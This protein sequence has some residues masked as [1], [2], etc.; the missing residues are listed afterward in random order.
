MDGIDRQFLLLCYCVPFCTRLGES[1]SYR[2]S[3]NLFTKCTTII[4]P[5]TRAAG[6]R[7]LECSSFCCSNVL[8]CVLQESVMETKST[9]LHYSRWLKLWSK[10][11]LLFLFYPSTKSNTILYV[12][13]FHLVQKPPWIS[14]KKNYHLKNINFQSIFEVNECMI[15][16][17]IEDFWR[18]NFNF[19]LQ[20]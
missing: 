7:D 3:C 15:C 2:R 11:W 1:A 19:T 16:F 13:G 14:K 18:C 5:G 17:W 20:I 10:D 8:D 4:C 12:N 9:I 6:G